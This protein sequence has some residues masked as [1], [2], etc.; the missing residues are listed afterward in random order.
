VNMRLRSSVVLAAVALIAGVLA[1]ASSRASIDRTQALASVADGYVQADRPERGYGAAPRLTISSRPLRRTYIRFRLARIARPTH[2]ALLRVW[3]HNSVPAGFRVHVA[4]NGWHER[5][6]T[7]GRSPRPGRRSVASG[8]VRRGWK[9]VDVTRLIPRA[10]SSVTFVLS[11]SSRAR[12]VLASREVGSR[13]PSLNVTPRPPAGSV[14]LA[15]AGD[16]AYAGAEDAQTAALLDAIDP[17]IVYTLGDNAYEDGTAKQFAT[18]YRPTWGRYRAKTRPT[19]GNHDYRTRNASGYFGYFGARAGDPAKGYYSF[20][21]GAWHVVV[22]NTNGE[23][24]CATVACHSGSAQERWLRADLAASRRQ[25][26]LAYWHHPRYSIGPQGTT[27]VTRALWEALYDDGVEL[28]LAGN[29]HNYQRWKPIDDEGEVDSARGIRSFVVGTGGKTPDGLGAHPNVEIANAGT[30]GVLKLT[31]KQ[32]G[33]DWQFV[34]V[35]GK[36]FTD[37]GSGTCH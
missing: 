18:W 30:P 26:T 31:L 9:H 32:G 36:T 11:P 14:V 25:C 3:A 21:A 23:G 16:I 34:P 7:F 10:G 15:G 13:G 8:P 24:A 33:Y 27:S 37:S 4:G 28:A 20:E 1:G 22:L 5:A 35:A 12:L 29:D 2:R 17:D 19:P 6:L